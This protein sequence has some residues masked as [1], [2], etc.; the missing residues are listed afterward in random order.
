MPYMQK[1]YFGDRVLSVDTNTLADYQVLPNSTLTVI[2]RSEKELE[3][4]A[5]NESNMRQRNAKEEGFKGDAFIFSVIFFF[6]S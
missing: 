1:L 5:I 3:A 2:K 4:E 6:W